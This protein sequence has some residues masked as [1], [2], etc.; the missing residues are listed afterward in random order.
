MDT[1]R[2]TLLK[3][4]MVFLAAQLAPVSTSLLAQT[5]SPASQ[6]QFNDGDVAR[7]KAQLA[8]QQKQIDEL[9]LALQDQKKLIERVNNSAPAPENRHFALPRNNALGEVASTTP[10]IPPAPAPAVAPAAASSALQKP[11]EGPA[12]PCE[13][14]PEGQTPAFIR[15]GSTCLV[16]VGFMDLTA[17]WRDKNA[18]SSIGSNFGSIPYNNV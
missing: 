9:K 8:E 15:L 7:L 16:P 6:S 5:L 10:F 17:L 2:A 18:A 12:N 1:M 4:A 13:A 3:A 11:A 14:N